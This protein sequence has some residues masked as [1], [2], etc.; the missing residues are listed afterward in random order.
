[1][2]RSAAAPSIQ[3]VEHR[4]YPHQWK[5]VEAEEQ[6]VALV[7]GIGSGKS[8]ALFFVLQ[9]WMQTQDPRSP[10]LWGAN[11]HNQL[12]KG[13]L[14]ICKRLLSECGIE[15]VHGKQPPPNWDVPLRNIYHEWHN[16]L[17]TENGYCIYCISLDDPDAHRG[18]E[19]GLALLDELAFAP[20][21]EALDVIEGRM[22]C[23][24]ATKHHIRIA[25]SPNGQ[26]WF[27]EV[28]DGPKK[29]DDYRFIH[30]TSYDNLSTGSAYKERL[31][32][33]YKGSDFDR[34]ILGLF[35]PRQ[36]DR[37]YTEF[38]PDV[39]IKEWEYDPT[40][41][42]YLGCDFNRSPLCWVL[43]QFSGEDLYIFDELFIEREATTIQACNIVRGK[44]PKS[45]L[46]AYP[47]ISAKFT[48]TASVMGITNDVEVMESQGIEVVLAFS[49]NP[50]HA[51][52]IEAVQ[53]R[54]RENRLFISAACEKLRHS[55]LSTMYKPG[56]RKIAK[57]K[58]A[59]SVAEHPS[60][61]LGY[62]VMGYDAGDGYA[63][64]NFM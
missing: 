40:L 61:A 46:Y 10:I 45:Y 29:V 34:E 42:I 11:T 2:S 47:D 50:I 48:S 49:K 55:L 56:E 28:F 26:N 20:N 18:T 13:S 22:R 21:R 51:E 52:R 32:K 33:R 6:T 27:W 62:L 54:F 5:F 58:K 23:Q 41:P 64:F 9:K 1:M 35:T 17:T 16:V 60:D 15:F 19:I 31:A 36:S 30:A 24:F 63:P 53:E 38:K 39:H 12:D 57:T 25:T 4:P 44:Y 8:H 7:G 43:G 59:A 3:T 14:A 37:C